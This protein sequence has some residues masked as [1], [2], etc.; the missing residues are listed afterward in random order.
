MSAITVLFGLMIITLGLFADEWHIKGLIAVFGSFFVI[1]GLRDIPAVRRCFPE[2]LQEV[3]K[4]S[5]RP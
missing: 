3:G 4:K 2:L 1:Y 5:S